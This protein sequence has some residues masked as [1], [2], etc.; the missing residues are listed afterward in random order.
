[1][2]LL[3]SRLRCPRCRAP[4]T[5][6]QDFTVP[7]YLAVRFASLFSIA[8]AGFVALVWGSLWLA[9]SIAIVGGVLMTIYELRVA[10]Y[11]CSQCKASYASSEIRAA[12]SNI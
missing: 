4:V 6:Q 11:V 8:T 3:F 12:Q 9:L 5:I 7:K 1:M 2:R 10:E